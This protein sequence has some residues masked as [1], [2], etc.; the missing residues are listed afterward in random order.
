MSDQANAKTVVVTGSTGLVGEPLVSELSGRGWHVIRAVR[1]PVRNTKNELFWNPDSG[2]IEREKLEGV[3]AIV[4]LAGENIAA[5]RWSDTFKQRIHHSRTKGTLLISE[6]ID[7]LERKPGVLVCASAIGYYGNRGDEVLPE[8][9]APGDDF[10]AHVCQQWEAACQPARDAG[11]RVANARIGVILSPDGGALA[12]VL[13]PFKLGGGGI[14]GNGRQFM[15]WIALNDVVS[16]L[17]FVVETPSIAGPVN[18]TAP[19]P[20]TNGEFTKTLGKV[21]SR[22]TIVPLPAF[23]AK[24]AF[25]EMGEALLLSSTRVESR[26]LQESDYEFALPE[27]EPALRSLLNKP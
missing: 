16:A 24:L 12:K 18:L 21:L 17:R 4:H 26:V 10:L 23:A 27:L 14:V 6:A 22:P 8:S 20:V 11:V 9:A 7:A 3:D 19:H 2:E 25:G 1:R 15:S 5:H 13:T